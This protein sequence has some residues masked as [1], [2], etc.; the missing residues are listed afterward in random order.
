MEKMNLGWSLFTCC[1]PHQVPFVPI[2]AFSVP[3]EPDS[4][5]PQYWTPVP[6]DFWLVFANK[7]LWWQ[8]RGQKEGVIISPTPPGLTTVLAV[9]ALSFQLSLGGS[10][11]MAQA[12]I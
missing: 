7:E 11:S 9:A 6:S 2:L 1:L 8:I 4:Y 10:L 12:H 3:Q 5:G